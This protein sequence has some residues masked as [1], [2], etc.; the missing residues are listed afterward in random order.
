MRTMLL[1]HP[2]EQNYLCFCKPS[3]DTLAR[4]GCPLTPSGWRRADSFFLLT[5]GCR[6]EPLC[7]PGILGA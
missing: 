6:G 7:S 1:R 4:V 5:C 2:E 3:E